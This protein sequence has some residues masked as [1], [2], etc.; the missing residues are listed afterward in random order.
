MF[1]QHFNDTDWIQAYRPFFFEKIAGITGLGK[2]KVLLCDS[3]RGMMAEVD[4][5]T[6][7]ANYQD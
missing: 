2:N 1:H 5:L 3:E 7:T 4:L 6:Q